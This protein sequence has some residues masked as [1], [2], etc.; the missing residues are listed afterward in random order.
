MSKSK[1]PVK[2]IRENCLFCCNGSSNEVSLCLVST[3]PL[4]E[5]RFGKN[6]YRT[7]RKMDDEQKKALADRLAASRG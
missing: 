5:W 1:N 2:A 6:P 4:H 7:V 3:C